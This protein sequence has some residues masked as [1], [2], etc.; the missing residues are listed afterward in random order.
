[1]INAAHV[2]PA[3][4]GVHPVAPGGEGH[5]FSLMCDDVAATVA[6]LA[7]DGEVQLYQPKHPTA[8]DR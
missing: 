3:E 6:A 7:A 1:V 8:H 4:I 2:P 5:E